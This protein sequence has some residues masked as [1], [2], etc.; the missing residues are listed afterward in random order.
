MSPRRACTPPPQYRL[1]EVAIVPP[2]TP[3]ALLYTNRCLDLLPLPLIQLQANASWTLHGAHPRKPAL[4]SAPETSARSARPAG[5]GA[6][7]P[8]ASPEGARATNL[9]LPSKRAQRLFTD[10][11]TRARLRARA[12]DPNLGKCP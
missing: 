4:L 9:G 11:R 3:G 5:R 6:R 7:G 1:H 8:C 2:R 10:R 12:S